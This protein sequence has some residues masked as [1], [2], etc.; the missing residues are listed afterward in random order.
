M[1]PSVPRT[2]LRIVITIFALHCVP[3]HGAQA[4][5]S[6]PDVRKI[7][8]L[9]DSITYSGQYIEILETWLRMRFPKWTGEIHNA[10]LPSET[11]SGLSEEGHAGGAFPRPDLHE[12]LGRVLNLVKPDLVI[13][14]YGMN[15]GIYLDFDETRFKRF[16]EGMLKLRSTAAESGASVIHVTPPAYDP[17]AGQK[18][19]FSYNRVLDRYSEWLVSKRSEGWTVIDL[20]THMNKHLAAKRLDN[21][22]YRLA[23]DGVHPTEAGH[24]VIAQPLLKHFGAPERVLNW[25]S[26]SDLQAIHPQGEALLKLVQ[27]KQRMMKDTWLSEA[28]HKRPGMN[29][30]LKLAEAQSQ[31]ARLDGQIASMARP[32]PGS[33]GSWHGFDRYDFE[34]AGK[35]VSVIAPNDPLPGRLWA[36]KGEFLDAFPAVEIALLERGVFIVYLSVPDLL[37]SPDAVRH[38]DECYRSLAET[39][40]MAR[41][42]ALI[43]LSRAGLYCYNWASKNPGTVA[44]IY[45]DAAVCDFKSWPGGKGRGKGS[46]RDWKLVLERYGFA[47]E[48][49]A[50]AYR[51]NPID[52]LEPL[53]AARVPLL[54]VYGDKDDAVPWEENTGIV[55]ERYKRLGGA[56]TL[57]AKPG[58][59]HHPH[60][61]TDPTPIVEF[62]LK[63][64]TPEK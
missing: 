61:L 62:I 44:C 21:A 40:R 31:A 23:P 63:H 51:G 15:D 6:P 58:V 5:A 64:I 22:A 28:G 36:W 47:S 54:H 30:G 2:M 52:N 33:L 13:A 59:G 35:R 60:G 3:M 46:A 50:L 25:K 14:C 26:P 37:G 11:V 1:K 17:P 43:A 48:A 42:P 45:A 38:W 57:I 7:L 56:I 16:Q 10:G 29:K 19:G 24:W 18:A 53:A 12:R 32:F 27:Q 34:A 9:G 39:H 4:L 20:H 55:A 8:F 41:K 49:E